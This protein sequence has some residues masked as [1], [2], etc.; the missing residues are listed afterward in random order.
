MKNFRCWFRHRFSRIKDCNLVTTRNQEYTYKIWE[1]RHCGDIVTG[2][3]PVYHPK[4]DNNT[5]KIKCDWKACAKNKSGYCNDKDTE[6]TFKSI[7]SDY[8]KKDY[9][10]CENFD[11]E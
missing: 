1:C 8:N 4:I 2:A 5:Y 11:W 9:M 3:K 7:K 6:I 10:Q